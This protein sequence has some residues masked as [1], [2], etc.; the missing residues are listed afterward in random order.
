MLDEPRGIKETYGFATAGW[1][2]A[3]I[4]GKVIAR[5]G[6]ALGVVPSETKDADWQS[7]MQYVQEEKKRS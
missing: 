7:L 2:V 4:V 5:I 1:N 3:P 6:P